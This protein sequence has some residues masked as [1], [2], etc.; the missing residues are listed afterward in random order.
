MKYIILFS[1]II[2]FFAC[3]NE[4]GQY[5]E[6]AQYG[7]SSDA[8]R[9]STLT[10]I[11]TNNVSQLTKIWEYRSGDA[12]DRSQIQCQPIVIDGVLYGTSPK[13]HLF[14]LEA[15]SGKELWRFDPFKVL[16]GENSWAG[17]NRGVTYFE[18][19]GVKRI[20]FC[21]GNFLMS[22]N[23]ENGQA[24]LAFG[25]K[26]KV[27]LQV[28]LSDDPKDQFLVVS[29]T[30]GVIY[31]DKIILGMRLSEGLDAAK[32]HIRAY[33]VKTGKQEWIFHTIP[34][35]NEEGY[36]TWDA[37]YIDKIGGAN[38]WAGMTLDTKN[39]I[40]F[41]PTGSATYDFFGGFRKGDN[42]YANSLLALDANTGKKV[43]HFQ[44]VHHDVWDRDI[45]A[46]PN[47]VSLN[48]KGKTIDAVAQITKQ[49]YVYLFERLTGKPVFPINEMPIPPSEMP[50]EWLSATQPIPTLPKPFMRQTLSE[51]DFLSITP[52]L[53]KEVLEI[54]KN[55]DYGN[56]WLSPKP[57]KGIIL[58]PGF[59]GGAEWGGASYDPV[60]NYLYVNAN[61]MPWLIDM[62]KNETN[63]TEDEGISAGQIYKANCANCHGV[64]LKGNPPAFPDLSNVKD[65]LSQ[66][67]VATILKNGKGA[68]PSF[69][70]LSEGE[71]HIL[72]DFLF[73]NKNANDKVELSGGKVKLQSP[74]VMKGYKRF[75]T[76]D[77]YPGIN[78][79]WGTL[80]AI[81]LNTGEIAWKVPLGEFP[82]LTAASIPITGRENYGGPV[83]T[84]S[85]LIFIA[86][87]ADEM[88]RVFNKKTGKMLWQTKLPAAGHATP[89]IY[90]VNGKQIIVI[91]CGGGKGSKSGDAYVAFALKK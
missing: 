25:D 86:A 39:A 83:N 88:F 45:P 60:N 17:T 28:G 44:F 84:A 62:V 71:R 29:N 31:K 59:D 1:L 53:K 63:A 67:V 90:E 41:V 37:N 16:G 76:K 26:G 22:V 38:N 55:Y 69:K 18:E 4:Q 78:P 6:W 51:K 82:E 13:L 20:L 42:L 19:G 15:A 77:G 61:E 33:N 56:M 12:T 2:F 46:N 75:L 8:A 58:F 48:I 74:Y 68:M 57:G 21:A 9:Y 80:N 47:L 43:W 5:N 40:V 27:D 72:V 30:P 24:D 32:G 7:G 73:G 70:H 35:A 64:D 23:A 54:V 3:S 87:T 89:A 10:E 14:A 85:G 36:N 66:K 34:N 50:G 81:N 91:A 79:P 11:D 49:G 52:A 65:R